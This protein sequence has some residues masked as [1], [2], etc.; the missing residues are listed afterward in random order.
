MK[1]IIYLY[2]SRVS[3]VKKL[4]PAVNKSSGEILAGWLWS[5]EGLSSLN[6]NRVSEKVVGPTGKGKSEPHS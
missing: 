6:R 3:Q 4:G 5:S 2:T 1:Q